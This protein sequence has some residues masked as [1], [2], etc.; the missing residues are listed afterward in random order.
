MKKAND[1][2]SQYK[3]KRYQKNKDRILDK[4]HLSKQEKWEL[5]ERLRIISE[6]F[7]KDPL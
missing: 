1:D 3:Q 4:P 5:R 7:S 2:I 6:A